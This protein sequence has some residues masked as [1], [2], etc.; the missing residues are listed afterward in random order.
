MLLTKDIMKKF[1][2]VFVGLMME[3]THFNADLFFECENL[4]FC[5]LSV[6]QQPRHSVSC[7]LEGG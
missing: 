2:V 3:C 7:Q 1:S 5:Q 6:N 4:I